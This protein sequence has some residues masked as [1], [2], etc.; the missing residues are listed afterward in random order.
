[1]AEDIL[2]R[3]PGRDAL[4][5]FL[6]ERP[7]LP[8]RE[9]A[10]LLGWPPQKLLVTAGEA[11]ALLSGNRVAWDEVAFRLVHAWP[12]AALLRKLGDAAILLPRELHL[13]RVPWELPIYLVRAMEVQAV[14]RRAMRDD[15]HALDAQEHVAEAL[16]LAI[17]DDTAVFFRNDEDF[18]AAYEYPGPS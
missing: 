6:T 5:H 13:T 9:A 7:E 16:H 14:L 11:D 18:I 10:R 2:P 3:L 15:V 17:D 1:M 12:R 8:V 4:V